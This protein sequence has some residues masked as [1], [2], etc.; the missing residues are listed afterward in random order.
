MNAV[1][2]VEQRPFKLRETVF[3]SDRYKTG[4]LCPGTEGFKKTPCRRCAGPFVITMVKEVWPTSQTGWLVSV[5][6]KRTGQKFVG[7]DS[8]WFVRR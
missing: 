7:F 2:R 5:K 3:R 6:H 8:S 4:C 1:D